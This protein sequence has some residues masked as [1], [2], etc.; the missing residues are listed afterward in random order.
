M[1]LERFWAELILIILNWD[2]LIMKLT[3]TSHTSRVNSLGVPQMPRQT[4][5]QWRPRIWRWGLLGRGGRKSAR[6]L[7]R[8]KRPLWYWDLFRLGWNWGT[9]PRNIT[10]LHELRRFYCRHY[11]LMCYHWCWHYW[12]HQRLHQ[13]M[14]LW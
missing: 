11:Y 2:A 4:R 9:V 5:F 14:R 8:G 6:D 7:R 3:K 1:R 12:T 10:W 13:N